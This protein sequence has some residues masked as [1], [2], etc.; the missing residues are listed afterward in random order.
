MISIRRRLTRELLGAALLLGGAGLAAMYLAARDA[1]IDQFD[2]ALNAKAQAIGTLTVAGPGGV[3]VDFSDR[4]LRGF[5]DRRRR[6][7]FELWGLDGAPLTR[8]GSLGPANLPRLPARVSRPRHWNLELPDRRP[9]RAVAVL[10]QPKTAS[11]AGPAPLLELVVA[12]DREGLEETL[13]QL[14]AIASGSALLLVAATVWL[15]PGVLR[16][17]LG[18]LERLGEQVAGIGTG[19]L[20]TRLDP[21]P[22]PAELV[23]IA[24]R[25]NG[26]L[27]RIQ[28]SFERER[29]FSADLAHE[30]RT[31]LAEL[32]SAAECAL[33]WPE[34]RDPAVDRDILAIAAQMEA[35]VGHMLALARGEQGQLAVRSEPVAVDRLVG[36]LWSRLAPRAAERGLVVDRRLE[37]LVLAAD[38]GLLRSIL[39][40][41]LENAAD[42]APRGGRIEL[43]TGPDGIVVANA[44]EDFG[45]EDLPRLFERFWRKEAARSG[46]QH[47][48][49]GLA[50]ARVFAEAM[51]WTLAAD[52]PRPNWLAFTLA[53][54]G[55]VRAGA[56]S[57]PER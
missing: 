28:E 50:V 3:Q 42:Y 1:A 4:L 10:F 22:L 46:G 17:G 16:R 38:P 11:A 41:L 27:A 20:Q 30:L 49:L 52:S 34:S 47:V 5:T 23:P 51:D 12:S 36:D 8:S 14:I 35:M 7:F 15:I 57:P 44:T 9:G 2:A 32:R 26:L 33:K 6:D 40:N 18:P 39:G 54:R 45:P 31:P 13:W 19:N 37:P 25:L 29:R 55:A 21:G 48:G 43:R 24:E 53:P 56:A